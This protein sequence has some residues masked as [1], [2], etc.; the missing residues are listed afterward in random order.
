LVK[1]AETKTVCSI[2]PT[3]II[4]EYYPPGTAIHDML[5]RHGEQ[6]AAKALAV[7]DGLASASVDRTFLYEAA[8]LHDIGI[9][10][11]D[12]PALGC[13]G[14]QPYIRHG[15]LGR[16]L[17][18]ARG[19]DRHALVCERHVG[20]GLSAEDIQRQGLPLP[21]RDMRPVTIEEEIICYADKF[22]SK[23]GR[24]DRPGGRTIRDITASLTRY[25]EVPLCRF[26]AWVQRFENGGPSAAR[27]GAMD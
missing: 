22:Y 17:L 6:V 18:E 20:V 11:T 13:H 19:L 8:M 10:Q 12:T 3:R 21:A 14:D 1:G 7:A 15:V 16:A 5:V 27:P 2:D 9:F 24:R 25:G 4:R 26:Q 23:K